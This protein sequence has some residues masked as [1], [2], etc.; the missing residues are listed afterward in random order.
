MTAVLDLAGP[1]APPRRN[2]ALVFAAPWESRVFGVTMALHQAG[3]FEWEEFRQ[4]LIAE[5]RDA[6]RG[7]W[8]A[9]AGALEKL[10]AATG[11][12]ASA[13]LAARVRAL[14]TRP[15]GHDH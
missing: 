7:Y 1:A 10:L 5:I 13:E 9:W 15:A 2:G 11:L 8:T 14:E 3:R 12:C 4:R 6:D